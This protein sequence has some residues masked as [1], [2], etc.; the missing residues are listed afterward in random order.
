M[1]KAIWTSRAF[2]NR[3][4]P[5]GSVSRETRRGKMQGVKKIKR[6]KDENGSSV[7]LVRRK[8]GKEIKKQ[9]NTIRC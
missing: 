7:R 6:K 4:C 5:E 2:E 9:Y 8:K 1:R 3:S